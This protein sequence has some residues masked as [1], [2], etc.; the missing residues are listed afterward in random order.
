MLQY[1]TKKKQKRKS[2]Y[3]KWNLNCVKSIFMAIQSL[4]LSHPTSTLFIH[5]I[6]N[7]HTGSYGN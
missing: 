5:A 4:F 7:I 3:Q 2:K 6:Y 1:K